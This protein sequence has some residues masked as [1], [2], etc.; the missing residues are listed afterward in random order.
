MGTDEEALR[1]RKLQQYNL[2]DTPREDAFDRITRLVTAVLNV[3][4]AAVTLVDRDRQWFKSEYGLNLAETPREQ[5]FCAHAMLGQEPMVVRDAV[6]DPRFASNPLVRG[7]P[8]IRFYVGV[9][10]R[11]ADG[12]PLGA[13]CGIDTRPRDI[14]QRELDIL[15]DLANLTMEQLELRLLATR[16]GLT[17][18][19]RRIPFLACAGRDLALAQGQGNPLACLMIDADNFKTINDEWGHAIGDEVLVRLVAAI[20]SELRP[21]DTLG[22][23]GGEEFCV[24]LP[25]T[26]LAGALQLAERVRRAVAAIRLPLADGEVGVTASIGAAE[27]EPADTTPGDLIQRADAALYDAKNLGRNRVAA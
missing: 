4:I 25:D 14:E 17:G 13:L 11:A 22:R 7:R 18:A 9:P 23:F 2:L 27:I 10:L 1:L 26:G 20:R 5:S 21:A 12:T 24:F 3:P 8:D 19:L 15:G 6:L 16:D